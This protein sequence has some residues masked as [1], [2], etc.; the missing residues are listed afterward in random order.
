MDKKPSQ[1]G[2]FSGEK[3]FG[4]K[5]SFDKRPGGSRNAQGE[6][7]PFG[8]SAQ[9]GE[10]KPYSGSPRPGGKFGEK[11]DGRPGNAGPRRPGNGFGKPANRPAPQM[12]PAAAPS[13]PSSNSRR[14]ALEIF[15]DVVR[16]DAFAALSLDDRMK[17]ANLSQLDKRFCAS[18][19]YRTLENLI[20][21][22]YA[23][24]FYLNDAEALEPKV[25]DILRISACQLLFHDRIPE[26]A[27]VDEAVKLTRALGMEGLTGLT[28]AVLRSMVREK[29]KIE[30]PK[31]EEGAKYLSIMYSVPMWL[32]E[33]L[34]AAYG[35]KMA[36][37]ICSYRN[38]EHFITIR[39][40]M[41]RLSDSEFEALMQ[42]KVWEMEKGAVPHAYR[43]RLASEIARDADYMNGSFSIQ[44]E[45]SMLAAQAVDV[46]RGMQVLDCCA[47]PG[48]KSA[49]LA[50]T[51]A[52]TGRV[53][54]WDLHEHRVTL[55][56]AMM[57]RMRLD[58]IR[59]V[60]RDASVL[61]ED[62]LG[63]MDAV[64][65]DAPC[66]GLGVMDNK[67][68]I[69]YR[70]TPESVEELTRIQEKLLNTCCQ[71]VKRGG[72]LVYSTCSMLPEE[73]CQQVEKFLADHP[74]FEIAP[75][76]ASFDEKFKAQY[77]AAGLQ[78]LPHRDGVEGFFIARMR[79]VK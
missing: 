61:K 77:T 15:Q 78:L 4:E 16:K 75:L 43:V 68:D 57:K 59:P 40:N 52:G 5:R 3:R 41:M 1:P 66:S 63:A 35:E 2:K 73:N 79:R 64:L 56:K 21:I 22:D 37:E 55:I 26:N 7:R 12:K 10:K 9:D 19:V 17:N 39:P 48:G 44:G 20:R 49:Y 54:A 25:R 34:I 11:R 24:S 69:K 14:V 71:Y 45:S 50:E 6:K 47:A 29:E 72:T 62:L 60:V 38:Q 28:N 13:L 67:P 74:E 46:K 36:Q 32:A 31:P 8:R 53:Y 65:L 70:A 58:N 76:P 33:R 51:M 23:L 30:W 18:I 42:K 27:I